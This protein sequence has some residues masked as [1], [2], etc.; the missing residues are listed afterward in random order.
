MKEMG[1]E[2]YNYGQMQK[3]EILKPLLEG[4]NDGRRKGFFCLAVNL[5]FPVRQQISIS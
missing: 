3:L 5:L 2:V 4:Y 1:V